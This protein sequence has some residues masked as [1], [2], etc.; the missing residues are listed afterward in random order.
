MFTIHMT[1]A[2]LWQLM[3]LSTNINSQKVY[4]TLNICSVSFKVKL[5]N[6]RQVQHKC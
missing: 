2:Y 1:I 5:G 6:K 3:T 4:V